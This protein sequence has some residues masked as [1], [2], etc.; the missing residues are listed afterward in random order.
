MRWLHRATSDGFLTLYNDAHVKVDYSCLPQCKSLLPCVLKL[1]LIS[2]KQ[3]NVLRQGERK[4]GQNVWRCLNVQL[5]GATG[6]TAHGL[7]EVIRNPIISRNRSSHNAEFRLEK[8]PC[9][10]AAD[11]IWRSQSVRRERESGWPSCK[12]INGL[13]P[14]PLTDK[15]VIMVST[16]ET[17]RLPMPVYI[18]MWGPCWRP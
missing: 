11:I 18:S 12:R 5:I 14:S 7:D 1:V 15:Y 3:L 4:R 13:C 9:M 2:K 6:P 10:P 8:F 17:G 16:V